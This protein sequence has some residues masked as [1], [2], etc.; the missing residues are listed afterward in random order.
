MT[1]LNIECVMA[2]KNK[3]LYKRK[4][5]DGREKGITERRMAADTVKTE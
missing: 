2:V 4:M 3:S 5:N 1:G